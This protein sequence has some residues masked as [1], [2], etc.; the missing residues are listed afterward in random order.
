MRRGGFRWVEAKRRRS[1]LATQR[2]RV[3][4]DGFRRLRCRIGDS[5]RE[6]E[7]ECC[8]STVGGVEGKFPSPQ[9]RLLRRRRELSEG[10]R[11]LG[12]RVGSKIGI[13]RER[14]LR[15]GG[16]ERGTT[17][18]Q[19][20]RDISKVALRSSSR[21]KGNTRHSPKPTARPL[22]PPPPP[23]SQP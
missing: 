3:E 11:K 15:V 4:D 16:T 8:C 13:E 20:T 12:T 9:I 10:G 14:D 6:K 22:S 21:Q 18:Q 23:P 2:E 7:L 19:T 5:W 17:A 1:E